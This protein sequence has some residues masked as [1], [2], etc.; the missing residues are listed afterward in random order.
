MPQVFLRAFLPESP[1]PNIEKYVLYSMRTKIYSIILINLLLCGHTQAQENPHKHPTAD[2]SFFNSK[3][4][5]GVADKRHLSASEREE[6]IS[7]QKRLFEE[8]KQEHRIY[9]DS[10]LVWVKEPVTFRKLGGASTFTGT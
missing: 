5:E 9:K 3:Y 10:E 6:F 1:A 7:L 8:S 2:P 4:W